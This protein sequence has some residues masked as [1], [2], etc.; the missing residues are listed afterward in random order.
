MVRSHPVYPLAY[1]DRWAW[2]GAV[3]RRMTLRQ[4][5]HRPK[6]SGERTCLERIKSPSHD[7]FATCPYV[8]YRTRTCIGGLEILCP[9]HWTNETKR[10]SE[11]NRY[12]RIQGPA[13]C[14]LH[15]PASAQMDLNHPKWFCR[16]FLPPGPAHK[17][18]ITHILC[19]MDS[20]RVERTPAVLQAAATT[21]S[22]YCP[23][24]CF[25]QV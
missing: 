3:I 20:V 10:P 19:K 1:E 7:R 13:C 25:L 12:L 9:F 23:N 22:A 11:S 17:L 8:S 21:E 2:Q 6:R 24:H 14:P 4:Q 15:Q 18:L 5:E 16:P